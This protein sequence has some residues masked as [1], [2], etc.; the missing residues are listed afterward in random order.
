MDSIGM[1]E[2][3]GLIAA[4]EGADVMLKVA[5]VRLLEKTIVGGGNVTITVAGDVAAVTASVDAA[6]ASI[7]KLGDNLLVT[8][9]V[10]ARPIDNISGIIEPSFNE[11][12]PFNKK[13]NSND[14]EPQ[15]GPKQTPP[16]KSEQKKKF[17]I[18]ADLKK[19]NVQ[20]ATLEVIPTNKTEL[21][22]TIKQNGMDKTLQILNG[23]KVVELRSLARDIDNFGINGRELAKSNKSKLL[24]E[25][26]SYY[27]NNN[28]IQ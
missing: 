15:G 5:D 11:D 20:T 26:G 7:N 1:I 18:K 23:I 2:T 19:E 6:A 25:F 16:V 28:I 3:R 9:H 24:S 10:I 27:K 4:I 21:E 22:R 8:K 12:W 13:S 17:P 14:D